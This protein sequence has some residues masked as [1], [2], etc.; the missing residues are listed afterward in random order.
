MRRGEPGSDVGADRVEG[1]VAEIEQTRVADD[2]VQPD[3]HHRED[4]D[5]D[6][7]VHVRKC[8]ED[9]NLEQGVG[10]GQLVRPQDRV[11]EGDGQHGQRQRDP[12]DHAAAAGRGR[13][14]SRGARANV[15]CGGTPAAHPSASTTTAITSGGTA[16]CRNGDC[17]SQRCASVLDAD[18]LERA[19]EAP[20]HAIP[21]VQP[22]HVSLPRASARRAAPRAGTR[23]SG[24]GS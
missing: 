19:P 5:R 16:R 24:S 23:G 6:H 12:P 7:R 9:R 11:G 3:R 22:R 10:S 13:R 18:G 4:R 2:D 14:R 15:G 17:A 20:L 8:L 21:H 1:D